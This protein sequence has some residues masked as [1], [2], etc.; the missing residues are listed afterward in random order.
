MKILID[1]SK[2][3]IQI[4]E[5]NIKIKQEKS[6]YYHIRLR[7]TM[8]N[9]HIKCR[10]LLDILLKVFSISGNTQLNAWQ[11][12]KPEHVEAQVC[13]NQGWWTASDLWEV[14]SVI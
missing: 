14:G 2:G 13:D 8:K 9:E 10:N 4:E 5:W 1:L 6:I 3:N 12:I 7:Y 11:N